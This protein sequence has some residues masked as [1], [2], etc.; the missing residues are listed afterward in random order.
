MASRLVRTRR[1]APALVPG[2]GPERGNDH[3]TKRRAQVPGLNLA[4]VALFAIAGCGDGRPGTVPVSGTV[5]YQGKPVAEAQVVFM[6]EGAR[7]ASAVTDAEGR[8]T[9][10]TFAPDDGAVAGEHRVTVSRWEKANPADTSLYP[11]MKSVL[12]VKYS[13]P[14]ETPLSRTVEPGPGHDFVLEITD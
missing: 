4:I 9:L 8:F 5:T 2:I 10:S 11:E 7:P 3:A 6:A 14:A 13:N 1:L 12:P